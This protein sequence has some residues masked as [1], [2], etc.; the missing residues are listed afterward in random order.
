MFHL[1]YLFYF[2]LLHLIIATPQLNLYYTDWV[3]E[4][5]NELQH[6]CLRAATNEATQ[7]GGLDIISYCMSELPS[8][9][10]IEDEDLFSKF[11]FVELSKQNITSQQLYLWSAPID[12]IERYQFYLNQL[13]T[14]NDSYLGKQIY[15]NC[16]MSRFGPKCQYEL[17]YHCPHHSSFYQIINY[18]YRSYPHNSTTFSCY[19]HLKCN[20]G[21]FP[22]CL[23]WRE[24]C[25]GKVDCPDDAIDEQHCWQLEINECKDDEHRC[26]NGQCI[27]I[28]G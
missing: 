6:N 20:R 8:E 27:Q 14:L 16:T 2:I 26:K 10:R 25:D 18:F 28:I 17:H 15:Y 21:P 11:T 5:D 24:I 3:S 12:L 22:A 13:S 19:I 23:D 7:Q 4:S 1:K 9:F